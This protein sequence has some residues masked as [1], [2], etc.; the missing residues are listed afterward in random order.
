MNQLANDIP[1]RIKQPSQ[2]C[3]H[4]GKNYKKRVNLEKHLTICELLQKNNRSKITI[5]DEEIPSQRKMYQIILELVNKCS[6]LE[7]KI[8]DMNKWVVKKKKKVN[9][10]EWLNTNMVPNISFKDIIDKIIVNDEDVK[11]LLDHS[12][13]DVLNEIFERSIYNYTENENPIF[14]FVQKVNVFYV[15]D[16]ASINMNMNSHV[17]DNSYKIWMELTREQLIKFLNRV[18]IKIMKSFYDW[19]K[20]KTNEIKCDD[21]FAI[22]CDKTLVKIM[23]CELQQE[24]ILSKI[25]NAMYGRMKKDMKTLIEYEFEF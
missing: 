24:S 7:E 5:E 1:N 2:C 23:S 22:L 10:L 18:H 12:I 3:I 14:A 21:H 13:Y 8:E 15:Y 9:I 16:Y 11:R 25:K 19:K 20:T 4:C 17:L 6:K